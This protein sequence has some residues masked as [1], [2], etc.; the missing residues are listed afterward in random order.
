MKLLDKKKIDKQK[1]KKSNDAQGECN[2]SF[3]IHIFDIKFSI[4][5]Q[6]PL[7]S[8]L[9]ITEQSN[10]SIPSKVLLVNKNKLGFGFG[11]TK[12]TIIAAPNQPADRFTN[13]SEIIT[14]QTGSTFAIMGNLAEKT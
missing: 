6:N 10:A 2:R 13:R 4:F 9:S 3:G 8:F 1:K 14:N 5:H 7:S 12:G 11:E